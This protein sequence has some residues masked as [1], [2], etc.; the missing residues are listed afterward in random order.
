MGVDLLCLEMKGNVVI[1]G[2]MMRAVVMIPDQAYAGKG[3]SKMLAM[4]HVILSWP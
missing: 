1:G 4:K 3:L 2:R